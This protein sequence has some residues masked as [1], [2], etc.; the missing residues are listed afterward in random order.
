[1]SGVAKA[2]GVTKSLI[3]HHFGTKQALWRAVKQ[4]CFAEYHTEQMGLL[5][6]PVALS[7]A[8]LQESMQAY[9]RFLLDH[10]EVIRLN[11]W[12]HLE[13]DRQ[14]AEPVVEMRDAGI[15]RITAAQELGL[16]SKDVPAPLLFL[17]FLGMVQAWFTD[18]ARQN[19]AEGNER[20]AA[21]SYLD[22]AWKIF[23]CG[24]SAAPL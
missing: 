9:F 17:T 23:A 7:V 20:D 14:N 21:L 22:S 15:A 1:M 4:R 11:A 13:G 3:H 6:S 19:R 8:V 10:P 24:V 2:S 5:T 16:L 12:V 18:P